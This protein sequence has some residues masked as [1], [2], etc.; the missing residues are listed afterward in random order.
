MLRKVEDEVNQIIYT[1]VEVKTYMVDLEKS[2]SIPLRK[3]PKVSEDLRIVE[4]EGVDFCPCCGTHVNRTGEVGILKILKTEKSKGAT[5]IYFQ[6]GRK[7]LEDYR[8]KHEVISDLNERFSAN[9]NTLIEKVNKY[10]EDFRKL[11]L[12]IKELKQEISLKEA[13]G[14]VKEAQGPV[15]YGCYEN[16]KIDEIMFIA[17]QVFLKGQY[18]FIGIS[19]E[20][21]KIFISHNTD[22][23]IHCGN[24]L[25]EEIKTFN[26]KGGGSPT[27][28]Q[29]SFEN[30]AELLKCG[31]NLRRMCRE[32]EDIQ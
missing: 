10:V 29:G 32:M 18:I 1:D 13:K 21:K 6:C 26:A 15:V 19:L 11:E 9:E 2:K 17:K 8:K 25:K 14:L 30:T 31:D 12:E 16:K 20:S 28:A 7:A 27:Q 24:L 4:I 5:R 23:I 3:Q 22:L